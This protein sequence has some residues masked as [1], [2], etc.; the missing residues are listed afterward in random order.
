MKGPGCGEPQQRE[1]VGGADTRLLSPTSCLCHGR[2]ARG[3]PRPGSKANPWGAHTAHLWKEKRG[4]EPSQGWGQ[5]GMRSEILG[6]ADRAGGSPL[7][8]DGHQLCL[9]PT[10]SLPLEPRWGPREN[11][12]RLTWRLKSL[13]SSPFLGGAG[14]WPF[15]SRSGGTEPSSPKTFSSWK[16]SV[17][18]IYPG[19]GSCESCSQSHSRSRPPTPVGQTTPHLV[20]PR[21]GHTACGKL[22]VEVLVSGL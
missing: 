1:G 13:C 9:L 20:L 8:T 12:A 14:G 19:I 7:P 4:H 5:A 21:D 10:N 22:L 3:S 2:A 16:H 11:T 17:S 18:T 6:T 15:Q